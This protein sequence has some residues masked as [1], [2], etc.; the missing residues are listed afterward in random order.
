MIIQKPSQQKLD[1]SVTVVVEYSDYEFYD[2]KNTVDSCAVVHAADDDASTWMIA[3]I[4]A[5][6]SSTLDY[7]IDEAR[8][9]FSA[10]PKATLLRS[11]EVRLSSA[12]ARS[13]AMSVATGDVLVFVDSA[14]VCAAGWLAPLVDAVLRHPDAI[15]SPHLDRVRDAVSLEYERT[16]DRLVSGLSWDLAV[17]MRNA[18]A[19]MVTDEGCCIKTAALRGNVV[20]VR[21]KLFVALGGYDSK[22][23]TAETNDAGHNVELSLRSWMCGVDVYTVPCSR[24]G[25]LNLRDPVKVRFIFDK[26]V[27]TNADV[28]RGIFVCSFTRKVPCSLNEFVQL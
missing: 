10:L 12:Q 25:V 23:A 7:I 14:V 21:R 22:L 3:Q 1:V 18:P 5:V 9:Y 2:I 20:A 28:A 15:V 6:D 8:K 26:T 16:D 17:R 24:V 13:A 19:E 4:V 11:S 27:G